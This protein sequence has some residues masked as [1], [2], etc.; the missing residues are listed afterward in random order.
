MIVARRFGLSKVWL[1][2]D[3]L[4]VVS[5]IS[6][7]IEG[8]SPTFLLLKNTI[9]LSKSFTSFNCSHVKGA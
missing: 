6:H 1:E 4:V 2:C 5:A 9:T 3:A 8:A 7:E